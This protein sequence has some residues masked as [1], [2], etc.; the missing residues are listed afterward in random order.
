MDL[1]MGGG[2]TKV[3]KN[4]MY[5]LAVV[6][7]LIIMLDLWFV[8]KMILFNKCKEHMPA[9]MSSPGTGLKY[10]SDSVFMRSEDDFEK[11]EGDFYKRYYL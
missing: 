7:I 5:V 11:R 1:M 9:R 10:L 4:L 2:S 6:I 3:N 8:Q